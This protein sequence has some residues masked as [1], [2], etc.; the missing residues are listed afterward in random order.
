MSKLSQQAMAEAIMELLQDRPLDKITIKDITD[1]CGLTRNTFYYHF[2]DVYEL[3]RWIFEEKT[4]EIMRR[5]QDD[6]DWEGGLEETLNY[7]YENQQMI[8]H[9]YESIS[10]ELVVRFINEVMMRHAKVIVGREARGMVCSE[11]AIQI[12]S[13]IYMSAAINNV[14]TWIQGGMKDTPEHLAQAYN[15]IFRGTISPMLE[16]AEQVTKIG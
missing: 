11:K 4:S 14:I 2:H 16:S 8:R 9:I 3:L 15:T 12:A 1:H 6:G 5:Y 13:E 7:L 10:D